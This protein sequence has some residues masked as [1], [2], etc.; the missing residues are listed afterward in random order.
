MR[1]ALLAA[2]AGAAIALAGLGASSASALTNVYLNNPTSV[3]F[4]EESLCLFVV[5]TV[6][7][8]EGWKNGDVLRAGESNPGLRLPLQTTVIEAAKIHDKWAPN[9]GLSGDMEFFADD[10]PFGETI[11]ECWGNVPGISCSVVDH[12]FAYLHQDDGSSSQLLGAAPSAEARFWSGTVAVKSGGLA[13]VPVATYS[14]SSQGSARERV[15]LHTKRGVIVGSGEKTI[16][17]GHRADVGVR[18]TKGVAKM[19]AHG[20]RID[21]EASVEHADG[22]EGTGETTT[23]VLT[24]LTPA[25]ERLIYLP[26]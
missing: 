3:S 8:P 22:T 20:E 5:G 13:L 24:K 19:I 4:T 10:A 16:Q 18:L 6:P 26:H 23:V 11:V 12:L 15:V 1:I 2:L 25:L 9:G 21:I 14:S 17:F 7:C